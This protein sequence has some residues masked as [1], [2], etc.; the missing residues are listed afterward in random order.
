MGRRICAPSPV[1]T[2]SSLQ[3]VT[4]SRVPTS[5]STML[6]PIT[7]SVIESM[8]QSYDASVQQSLKKL[9]HHSFVIT[10]PH[11]HGHPI[12][13]ASD[14]FLHM[15]GYLAEEVLGRNPK[16]LQGP[17]TDRQ[18]VFQ[19]RDSV[20]EGKPC[21]VVLLNYTK[22]GWPFQIVLQMAPVFSQND[23]RLL[24]FVGTQTPLFN[25]S[26]R[27]GKHAVQSAPTLL[28]LQKGSYAFLGQKGLLNTENAGH[29]SYLPYSNGYR[30]TGSCTESQKKKKMKVALTVLQLV[31]HELTKSRELKSAEVLRGRYLSENAETALCSSLT[32]ALTRI[33]QSFVISNPN[34]PGMLIVYASDKFLHL[35][36]Y[37]KDE[38]IGRNCRFLQGQDTDTRV[39]QQIRDCIKAEK[40]CTVRLLNYRKDGLPFWNLL[41]V[42]PVRDHTAKVVYFVGVQWELGSDCCQTSDIAPVMQQL[43]A[44]GAIKVAVRSLQ[45][46]GLRRSFGP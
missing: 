23:G 36:G 11:L 2:S 45:G 34:L 37:Q 16:F 29:F 17:D 30:Q 18:S 21:H 31:I 9:R 3:T 15:S 46:Q 12:V 13:Y 1:P 6:A 24:H 26:P 19:I 4:E 8:S 39:V 35:T 28:E 40:A 20:C 14:T 7:Q 41:H 43:G 5:P 10:D 22:Q 38:V 33:Q 44:V 32:L 42:A 27:L 25:C